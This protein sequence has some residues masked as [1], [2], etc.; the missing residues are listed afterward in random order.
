MSDHVFDGVKWSLWVVKHGPSDVVFA[1]T[2]T[3]VVDHNE[4]PEAALLVLLYPKPNVV[5]RLLNRGVVKVFLPCYVSIAEPVLLDVC[6]EVLKVVL[7]FRKIFKLSIVAVTFS[8]Q[9]IV[10]ISK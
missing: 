6:R 9:P 10:M 1:Y 7:D 2:M 3:A 8:K 5:Y 4:R